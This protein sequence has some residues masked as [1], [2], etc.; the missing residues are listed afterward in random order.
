MSEKNLDYYLN[1]N[2]TLLEGEDLDFDDK[3]HHCI[4]IKEIPSFLFC[5]KTPERAREKY[6]QQLK[7]TLQV[8]LERGEHIIEPGE[9]EEE[10][11]WENLCP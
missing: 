2:W 3:P 10:P 7:W 11:D 5:A 4:E 9:D 1:L 6:K 8:M